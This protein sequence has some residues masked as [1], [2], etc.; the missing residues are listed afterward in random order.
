MS[1]VNQNYNLIIYASIFPIILVGIIIGIFILFSRKKNRLIREKQQ[2]YI[3]F[4][5]EINKTKIEIKDQT[6]K[7]IGRELHDNIGQL[8]TVT[9]I[10]LKELMEELNHPK[11]EDLNNI[12]EKTLSE[13]RLLSKLINSDVVLENG[14]IESLNNQK[15]MLEKSGV[16][17]L[18][19]II[20][21]TLVDINLGHELILFRIIQESISNA[22]KYSENET[23][24][25][26]LDYNIDV[27]KIIFKDFGKGFNIDTIQKGNGLTN[28]KN[29][30][31][32]IN[33]TFDLVSN[34][35]NGT[36][37]TL[38]YNYHE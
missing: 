25:I 1:E 24:E 20:R 5:N 9:R 34:E 32:I 33:T 8:L 13:V 26:T 18:N 28:M 29:R 30:A 19:I 38:N 37:I 3:N 31:E 14:L 12:T 35:E 21:G 6:L 23:F 36:T 16:Y 4:N 11:L 2:D 17:K 7:E 10:Q 22:I 15:I 27:L